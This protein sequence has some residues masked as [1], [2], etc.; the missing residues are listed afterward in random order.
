MDF[1]DTS[2]EAA[3]RSEARAWLEKN[4]TRLGPQQRPATIPEFRKRSDAILRAKE[5]M[6]CK[7]D[8]RWACLTWPEEFGGRAASR[9]Q[10]V[11][12]E[13]E[14]L[15]F[16][17]APNMFTIGQG[18]L[19][20]TIM[21]HG[22]EEQKARYLGP[23]L[24]ADEVW[25]QLFSEPAAGSDLA[26]LA[27]RAVRSGDDWIVNGQKIWTSGAQY[28]DFGMLLTRT[29]PDHPK[30]KGITY[31]IVDMRSPGIE[32]RPIRQ[33]S[34]ASTFNEVFFTDLRVPDGNRIGEVNEGWRG[35]LTTLMNER[36]TLSGG[37]V[38]PGFAE[39]LELARTVRRGGRP[40]VED[41]AVRARLAD[42]YV[43]Q[44]GVQY[45]RYRSLS[46]L[47]RGAT[48]G[49]ESSIGK[50]VSAPLRQE[51]SG[52][53]LEL[54]G[55]AGATVNAREVPLGASFA[56][57]YLA[58]PGGRIAGGTDEVLRN[59]VAERVLGLPPEPRVDKGVPFSKIPTGSDS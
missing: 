42:I 3:F 34:G 1:D 32:V 19:G 53:A 12:W 44:K 27:T 47:S 54:L 41:A 13:Q 25:C 40:A 21:A 5:W 51:M 46:A 50:I 57:S 45:A 6:A 37:G 16:R 9:I 52:F 48:P 26:G 17:T 24:R 29:N 28:C 4:A 59:I 35:A 30:H 43:R 55:P 2:E 39:L 33:M 36:Q 22:T 8:G 56:E 18:M 23:M 14:E 31:L 10:N 49:P 20:P 58:S 15:R 11:I 7:A 38:G